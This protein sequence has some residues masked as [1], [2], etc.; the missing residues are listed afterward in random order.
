[1]KCPAPVPASSQPG[2]PLNIILHPRF[3]Q[4]LQWAA[5]TACVALCVMAIIIAIEHPITINAITSGQVYAL[6]LHGPALHAHWC[7]PVLSAVIPSLISAVALTGLLATYR[8]R[9]L[10]V[11]RETETLKKHGP[12][13]G[14]LF[15]LFLAE[16]AGSGRLH[17]AASAVISLCLAW[18]WLVSAE[19]LIEMASVLGGTLLI[20]GLGSACLFSGLFAFAN[21]VP[22]IKA[23]LAARSRRRLGRQFDLLPSHE[24]ASFRHRAWQEGLDS[25][26]ELL[27]QAAV[28]DYAARRK[29]AQDRAQELSVGCPAVGAASA[30][31]PNRRF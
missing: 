17:W 8:G 14:P 15:D 19:T 5:T 4:A 10:S 1:M 24:K 28:Q 23:L 26:N 13:E 27:Q 25:E 12:G 18:A 21:P 22:R 7:I 11:A 6:A 30:P 29:Q 3:G 31:A 20:V 16:R 9:V 2:A